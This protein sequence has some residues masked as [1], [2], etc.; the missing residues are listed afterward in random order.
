MIFLKKHKILSGLVIFFI[1]AFAV[2]AYGQQQGYFPFNGNTFKVRNGATQTVESGGKLTVASGATFTIAS[3]AIFTNNSPIVALLADSTLMS[4]TSGYI[5]IARP[6]AA[7]TTATLPTAV[8]N[9]EF[10]FFVADSDSLRITAASGDSI[11]DNTGTAYKTTTSVAGSIFLKALDTTRWFMFP[12][13]GTWT[14]Y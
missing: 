11:I 12:Y 10:T 14:S 1:L 9:A 3:G 6:V 8:T 5:Y 13:I 4:Y 7:K 2:L